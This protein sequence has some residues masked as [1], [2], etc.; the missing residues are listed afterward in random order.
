MEE[1][2]LPNPPWLPLLNALHKEWREAEILK[3]RNPDP[4][5][6]LHL[7]KVGKWPP[8]SKTFN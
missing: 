6:E 5:I 8:G 4:E 1:H 7:F 3:G 2:T